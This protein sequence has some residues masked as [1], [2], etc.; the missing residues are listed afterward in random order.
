MDEP[1]ISLCCITGNE[2]PAMEGFL[3]SFKEAFDELCIVRAIGALEH[4]RTLTIA[5]DWCRKN[6]KGFKGGE[7]K[8]ARVETGF[9]GTGVDPMNPATWPHVDDFAAAR[10]QAWALASHPWQMWADIDDLLAPALP[11]KRG[12]AELIRHWAMQGSHDQV[13]FAYDL[14]SQSQSCMRERLFRSGCST[15]IQPLH[16]QCRLLPER[17]RPWKG[18]HEDRVVY[19]HAPQ[20]NKDRD[21]MRNRRVMAFHLRH[22]N[23]FAFEMHREWFY[24]WAHKKKPEDAEEA[25]KWAEIAQQTK[26]MAEQRY[27]MLLHQARI[28]AERDVEHAMDLCWSAIRINPRS[29]AG[30]GDL[31]GYELRA[32]RG[33]RAAVATAFMQSIPKQRA[34]GYPHSDHYYGWQGLHLRALT[35]RAAGQPDEA[36]KL[37]DEV[38]AKNGKRI[39]LLHATRGRAKKA[40]E[41]RNTWFRSAFVPLGVEHIFAIDA[42][43]KESLELL[44]NYRHVIVNEPRGCV[45]A[46]NAAAAAS[47]GQVLMQLSDDW[48]PPADWDALVWDALEMAATERRGKLPVLTPQNIADVGSVPLVLAVHDNHRTDALL[49][50]A[51]LTRARYEHQGAEMFSAEY[52][53]VWS[54]NEFT[55]RAYDDG[56]VVQAQHIV[57]DHAHPIW[58]GKP[59]EQWDE[60][61]RR[62]NAPERYEEGLAIFNRRNAKHAFQPA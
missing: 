15:W 11:G 32:A 20:A 55:L 23:A 8:N 27:D 59:V 12:G 35:L 37:E 25:T 39:S 6:A 40:L 14:R 1:R 13:F 38:F 9:P 30:W 62:Q 19:E 10:N 18:L 34:N 4:D 29:R 16:E 21:L 41:A 22:L 56:V 44:K 54:D 24:D 3:D 58:Q 45:K 2:E 47:S 7:Y 48:T 50:M 42:D 31:A 61:Y 28:A 43:D 17:G 49:C 60:T 5:K 33:G 57:F 53:G 52:F 26:C 36:Q 46:W 51:I